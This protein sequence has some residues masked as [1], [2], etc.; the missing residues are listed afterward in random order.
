MTEREEIEAYL[1]DLL[2]DDWEMQFV[3]GGA[4]TSSEATNDEVWAARD[5]AAEV[6]K[7]ARPDLDWNEDLEHT[8]REAWWRLWVSSDDVDIEAQAIDDLYPPED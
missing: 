8:I 1:A 3:I 4:S 6:V 7:A 5:R 2:G